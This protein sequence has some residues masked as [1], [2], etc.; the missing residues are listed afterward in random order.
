VISCDYLSSDSLLARDSADI[1]NW[2]TQMAGS[3]SVKKYLT[4]ND[5]PRG[6]RLRDSVPQGHY[7]TSRQKAIQ[8]SGN[9]S[10]WKKMR[11]HTSQLTCS[12]KPR[13]RSNIDNQFI[14][15]HEIQEL[16]RIIL[17]RL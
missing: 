14:Q 6:P 4:L 12:I 16:W 10:S 1:N 3:K 11:F 7:T 2:S 9:L 8:F 13:T 15:I 17:G 5:E